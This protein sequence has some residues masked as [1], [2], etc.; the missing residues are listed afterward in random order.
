[1]AL[2][3]IQFGKTYLPEQLRRFSTSVGKEFNA[4]IGRV[5]D[6]ALM[7][8]ISVEATPYDADINDALLVDDD[9]VGGVVTI[10]LPSAAA[11]RG[12]KYYIK[13]IG[14]TANVIIDA[15]AL[16]TIDGGL[17]ATLTTQYESITIFCDGTTWWIL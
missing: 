6:V 12:K 7:S 2:V 16:E 14:S 5:N 8:S 1:M 3:K 9:A 15:S 13:K 17:T 10:D 4:L 11:S